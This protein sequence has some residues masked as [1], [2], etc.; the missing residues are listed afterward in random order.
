MDGIFLVVVHLGSG[1]ILD[2]KRKMHH[3]SIA[4]Y[5]ADLEDSTM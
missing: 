5:A 1:R 4:G 2:T 3:E